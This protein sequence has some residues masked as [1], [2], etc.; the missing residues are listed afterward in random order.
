MNALSVL[1]V[2]AGL[3]GFPAAAAAPTDEQTG[4]VIAPGWEVARAN[5]G[6]C[7]SYRLITAQGGDA[8]FWRD[9]IRW[10]QRTQNLWEIPTATEEVLIE[11][12][13]GA[14]GEGEWGR[15]PPV[16]ARLL[17]PP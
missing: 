14:Y 1:L 17:P 7:H 11:Y 6:A 2:A 10:M 15:R 16:P 12:L 8:A 5:C 9:T 13:A 4:L 3:A